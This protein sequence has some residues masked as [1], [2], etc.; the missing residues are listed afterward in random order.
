MPTCTTSE[1]GVARIRYSTLLADIDALLA[2]IDALQCTVTYRTEIL[3]EMRN[4]T[5]IN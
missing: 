5:L 1:A 3:Q 2:D 4:A